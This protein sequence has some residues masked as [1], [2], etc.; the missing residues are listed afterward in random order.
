[1]MNCGIFF[2]M[3]LRF[4]SVAGLSYLPRLRYVTNL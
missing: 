4:V 1:M 2:V 3:T